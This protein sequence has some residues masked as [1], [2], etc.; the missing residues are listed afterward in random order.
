MFGW[1]RRKKQQPAPKA[2]PK[3]RKR[4]ASK[5]KKKAV[6]QKP[7]RQQQADKRQALHDAWDKQ[8]PGALFEMVQLVQRKDG[9]YRCVF[10]GGKVYDGEIVVAEARC[11]ANDKYSRQDAARTLRETYG[12]DE[13]GELYWWA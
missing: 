13:H 2:A 9:R 5:R 3:P 12:V 11:W 8:R 6:A 4:K 10:P 7:T 1:F